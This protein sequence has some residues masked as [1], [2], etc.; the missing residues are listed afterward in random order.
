LITNSRFNAIQNQQATV[1]PLRQWMLGNQ[2][3]GQLEFE[4]T[5]FDRNILG[6]E[7]GYAFYPGTTPHDHAAYNLPA[8]ES[9][10]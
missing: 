4:I 5:A 9:S 7:S 6:R 10:E 1:G 2:F 8:R 3:C